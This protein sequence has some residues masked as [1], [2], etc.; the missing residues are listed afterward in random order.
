MFSVVIPLYNKELSIRNTIQSV[1]DQTCQDFEIVVVNDGST[2]NSAAV[3][4]AIEDDRI[5][6]IHQKNQGVSAARNRGIEEARCEWIAFLDG[7]DLWQPNHLEEV[8]EA[9]ELYPNEKIYVTSFEYSDKRK[10]FRHSRA[11]KIFRING[12]FLEA[13]DEPLMWTSIVVVHKSCIEKVGGFDKQLDRG[14]DLE[15][16]ARLAKSYPIVKSA[17]YTSIYRVD[18]EN[19]SDSRVVGKNSLVFN[20]DL[21]SINDGFER[22]YFIHIIEHKLKGFAVT[23]NVRGFLKLYRMHYRYVSLYR[24]FTRR[25]GKAKGA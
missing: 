17:V 14:E 22:R 19:R 24:V 23:F 5:R 10:I 21:N 2:D 8:S 15:F 25:K 20:L 18:A 7:D 9:M 4:E 13:M 11:S 12:Y 1:L 3:V 6:L 16:W